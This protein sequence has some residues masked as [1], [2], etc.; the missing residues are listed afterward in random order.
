MS[1]VEE[2]YLAIQKLRGGNVPWEELDRRTQDMF[3]QAI[4]V[5]VQI[6]SLRK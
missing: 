6:S 1:K 3:M 2:F 4:S 5:L